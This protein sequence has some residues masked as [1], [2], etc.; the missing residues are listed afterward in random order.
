MSRFRPG[1]FFGVTAGALAILAL[2]VYGPATLLGPLPVVRATILTPAAAPANPSPPA[3]PSTGASAVIPLETAGRTDAAP[4]AVAGNADP[5]PM[6]SAAKLV[7]ALVVLDAK[8]LETGRT[9]PSMTITA[10]DYQGYLDYANEDARTVAV[11]QG[12]TW[13]ERELLQALIL[14]SSNNHADTIARW[15]FG[16]MGAYLDAAAAWLAE[17]KLTG[18]HVADANGLHDASAGTAPDLAR[19]AGIAITTPAIAELLAN[20][21]S[22][23]ADRRGVENTTAYLPELGL[24]GISRSYTDAAG[25]CFLFTGQ[26]GE[27]DGAYRFAGALL[28]EPDYDTL[29]AD[30]TALMESAV[31]GVHNLDVLSEGDAFV[32]FESAWGQTANGVVGV[33]KSRYGWQAAGATD[34]DVHLEP[35]S[36]RGGGSPVGRVAVTAAGDS[37]SS[38]LV[39]DRGISDPGPGWRLLNPVPVISAWIDSGH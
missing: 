8:P 2:G 29:S 3:L 1:R 20:P 16:S 11:F 38:A 7:T 6:A 24:T 12:E 28:G 30:L 10:E 9:G 13:T 33:S 34:A 21:S 5:M 32:R 27:G 31:A 15:A 22:A 35:F 25:V 14:G 36:T 37:V 19:L 18:T 17:H 4:L 26:V 39:L 23:L